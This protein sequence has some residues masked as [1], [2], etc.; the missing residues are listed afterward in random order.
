MQ[1]KIQHK[2]CWH[3]YIYHYN[4]HQEICTLNVKM[5]VLTNTVPCPQLVT[6]R[7]QLNKKLSNSVVGR[8]TK[9]QT[10]WLTGLAKY[11]RYCCCQPTAMQSESGLNVP[12][13]AKTEP[14]TGILSHSRT[15]DDEAHL[16][17]KTFSLNSSLSWIVVM[18]ASDLIC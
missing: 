4:R 9:L 14:S 8:R 17:S 6:P 7:S 15:S 5:S 16:D 1:I 10:Q 11:G 12:K 3:F 2:Y 13:L 18:M